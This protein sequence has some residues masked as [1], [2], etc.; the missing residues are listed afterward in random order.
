MSITVTTNNNHG[1][2]NLP[3]ALGLVN[4]MFC[5]SEVR[6]TLVESKTEGPGLRCHRFAASA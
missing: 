1:H 6:L 4:V 3:D 2:P 5:A